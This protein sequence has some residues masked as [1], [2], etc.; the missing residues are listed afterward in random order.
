M[1]GSDFCDHDIFHSVH[2]I[3]L[4]SKKEVMSKKEHDNL[5]NFQKSSQITVLV[6]YLMELSR[7]MCFLVTYA[8]G[9]RGWPAG[10]LRGD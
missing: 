3:F 6:G 10:G 1:K 2:L 9:G 4:A 8:P 5:V 7:L